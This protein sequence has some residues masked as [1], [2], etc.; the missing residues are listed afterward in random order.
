[1]TTSGHGK[2]IV[3]GRLL[4]QVDNSG[5][6]KGHLGIVTWPY[7]GQLC[8]R[9]IVIISDKHCSCFLFSSFRAEI[10][11]TPFTREH[12]RGKKTRHNVASMQHVFWMIPLLEVGCLFSKFSLRYKHLI[13]LSLFMQSK[14]VNN[15]PL[16]INKRT[17]QVKL[18]YDNMSN[19]YG[20]AS[21]SIVWLLYSTKKLYSK[22]MAKHH[23]LELRLCFQTRDIAWRRCPIS[24]VSE[25][26]A[27]WR[28][29]YVTVRN[30]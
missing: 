13:P 29:K 19:F 24:P 3:T 8:H 12:K 27:D 11:S 30:K 16:P 2:K 4:S 10:D 5:V 14:S 23:I 18:V 21:A 25:L 9:V 1:M 22:V 15:T 28:C 20:I 26:W 6:L 7:F 17:Q